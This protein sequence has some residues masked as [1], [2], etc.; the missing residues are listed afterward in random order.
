MAVWDIFQD[1][2]VNLETEFG[3]EIAES[4]WAL[5]PPWPRL[6]YLLTQFL[7]RLVVASVATFALPGHD[8]S[9]VRFHSRRKTYLGCSCGGVYVLGYALACAMT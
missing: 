6:C 2:F 7:S 3:W 1:F 8:V 4:E 9:T 5:W